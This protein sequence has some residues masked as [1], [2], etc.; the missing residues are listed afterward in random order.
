MRHLKNGI[1]DGRDGNNKENDAEG[2]CN[3]G[4]NFDEVVDLDVESALILYRVECR[5]RDVAQESAIACGIHHNFAAAFCEKRA[6][7]RQIFR[8]KG[9]FVSHFRDAAQRFRL[10]SERAVVDLK[11]GVNSKNAGDDQPERAIQ[12]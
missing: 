6:V 1:L 5:R 7:K 8:L 3:R 9:T 11:K 12:P 4:H 10:A 2:D